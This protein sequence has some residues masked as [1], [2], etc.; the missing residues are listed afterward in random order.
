MLF[1]F[2]YSFLLTQGSPVYKSFDQGRTFHTV[3]YSGLLD[4]SACLTTSLATVSVVSVIGD[5][6]YTDK[7]PSAPLS[8]EQI[9]FPYRPV[10]IDTQD[11]LTDVGMSENGQYV[12]ALYGS[13]RKPGSGAFLSSDQGAS[14]NHLSLE[15][16]QFN[17]YSTIISN[18]AKTIGII[19]STA[20]VDSRLHLSYDGGSTFASSASTAGCNVIA[21]STDLQHIYL[22]TT[23]AVPTVLVS[24]DSGVTFNTVLLNYTNFYMF[25]FAATSADGSKVF[26]TTFDTHGNGY[27]YRSDSFGAEFVQL[28]RE[29]AE[30]DHMALSQPQPFLPVV[31]WNQVVT[32]SDGTFIAALKYLSNLVY[33]SHDGGVTWVRNS[34][35]PEQFLYMCMN[36]DGSKMVGVATSIYTSLDRG[37]SWGIDTES[38]VNGWDM[39]KLSSD[40]SVGVIRRFYI[41]SQFGSETSVYMNTAGPPSASP[42]PL[43]TN[44]PVSGKNILS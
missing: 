7:A 36:S 19:G 13:S 12:L 8:P 1:F 25:T 10:G 32:S 37:L 18:D 21:A 24:H 43:P 30:S 35:A 40:G 23:A 33:Y 9:G 3:T 26:L 44:E 5:G 4:Y 15:A 6:F 28:A 38:D 22:G 29:P 17:E 20:D 2:T 31:D 11:L 39:C 41:D 34:A 27:I 42:T 14:W 16:T